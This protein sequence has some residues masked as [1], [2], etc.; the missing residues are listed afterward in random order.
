MKAIS[1]DSKELANAIR[2]AEGN[3]ESGTISQNIIW[4][5]SRSIERFYKIEKSDL[6]GSSFT[7]D[8]CAGKFRDKRKKSTCFVL[9]YR[10]GW[11]VTDIYRD[12]HGTVRVIATLSDRTKN[13][14]I[15]KM[16]VPAI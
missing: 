9:E 13:A 15:E 7:V 11:Q 4:M 14:I 12:S 2:A 16:C 10:N 5:T 8:L 1:I 6:E 3:A